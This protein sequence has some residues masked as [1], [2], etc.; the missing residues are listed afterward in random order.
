MGNFTAAILIAIGIYITA[1][2]WGNF[3]WSLSCLLGLIGYACVRYIYFLIRRHR[4]IKNAM[5]RSSI[6]I[7]S[8]ILARRSRVR[9][10]GD[11]PNSSSCRLMSR[12]GPVPDE[13]TGGNASLSN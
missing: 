9:F 12:A 5:A 1:E 10:G 4:F 7:R 13:K 2:I 8:E 3:G 6:K 11:N